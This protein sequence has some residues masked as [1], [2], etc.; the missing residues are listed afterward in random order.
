MLSPLRSALVL[1]VLASSAVVAWAKDPPP[2]TETK[3]PAATTDAKENRF[4]K[5]IAK[6][7]EADRDPMKKPKEGQILFVGSS[8]VRLWKLAD[9]FPGMDVLNRGFGGAHVSD[10]VHFA[11]RI[12]MPYKPRQIIFYAGDNDLNANKSPEQVAKDFQSF[13]EIVRQDLPEVPILC[14][15]VKPS[16]SRLRLLDKQKATNKLLQEYCEKNA[17]LTYVD[18]FSPM[19]TAEGEP[20]PDIFRDDKLHMNEAGY[21]I[22]ANKLQPLLNR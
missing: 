13:V 8:S 5:D 4:E 19:L 9:S 2:A 17:H 14:L 3:P 11:K 16:P 15:A 20:K 18:V 12:V 10:C 6:F 21:K 1:L 7:E 22:W